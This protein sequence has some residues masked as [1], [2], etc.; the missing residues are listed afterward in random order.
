MSAIQ[1]MQSKRPTGHTFRHTCAT[2]PLEG[3]HDIGTVRE[4]PGQKDIQ[5]TMNYTHAPD[6]GGKGVQSSESGWRLAVGGL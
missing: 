4:P 3:G 6:R 2:K 1:M 5:T